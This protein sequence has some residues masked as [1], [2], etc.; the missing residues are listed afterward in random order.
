MGIRMRISW[1]VR[2]WTAFFFEV[3]RAAGCFAWRWVADAGVR[4]RLVR[5]LLARATR[6]RSTRALHRLEPRALGRRASARR[7]R[8]VRHLRV[9]LLRAQFH[10]PHGR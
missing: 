3:A 9:K 5:G 10:E 6:A 4:R 2:L 1:C 7:V 8:R